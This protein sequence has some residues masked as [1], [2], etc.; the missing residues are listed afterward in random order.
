VVLGT[1]L[2]AAPAAATTTP[3]Q[4]TSPTLAGSGDLR[5][6]T[7]VTGDQ[8]MVQ[9]GR[10]RS[11][12]PGEGRE[13]MTFSART[14]GGHDI[15]VPADAMRLVSQGRLDRRLFDVTTLLEFG[16]DDERRDTLPLI[17]THPENRPAPRLATATVSREL[18]SIEAVAITATKGRQT[19]EALTDGTTTRRTAG[20]VT[21][22]WLDGKRKSTLEHSVPQI[23]APAAWEAGLTGEGTTVAVL[24]TGVDQTHPDLADRETAERNFTDAPDNVDRVGHGTHV[25]SIVA[26]T[27]AKSDGRFRGV[28]SGTRILDG[29][30]LDDNGWGLES[31]IVAG[32]EWA[33]EQGADV[34]NMSLGGG[35]TEGIDPLEEAVDTLSAEHGT[36][37]VIAAGNSGPDAGSV[38][39]PGSA[40]AA[41]TVGAVDRDDQLADFSSR[42]P[43]IGDGGIK[44]DITAPGV[45]IVAALHSEGT[46]GEPVVDG[47]TPLS[48]T[49]MATPHVSG[50]AALLA[51]RHPDWT[52]ARLKAAL[53]AS[54]RPNPAL[55]P[56]EQGSG[57]VDVPAALA[58]TVVTEPTSVGLGTAAWP[59]DDDQPVSQELT[60]QNLSD[61][62]L[63]L[64]LSIEARGPDGTP[65]DL[66]SLSA[67]ELTVPAGGTASVTVTGDT[68]LG[69]ADG[70]YSGAVVATGN[71]STT[72]TPVAITREVESYD[73]TVNVLGRDGEPTADYVATLGGLDNLEYRYP[74]DE[75]GSLR[76][77]VPK[78]RYLLDAVVSDGQAEHLH[79]ILHPGLL[80]DRDLTVTADARTTRPIQVTPPADADLAL[81]DIGYTIETET[82]SNNLAILTHD[83]STVSTA[84]IADELPGSTLTGKVNT[85]WFAE[86][87]SF[88]GLSWF[89]EGELPTGFER[90]VRQRDLATL[91]AEWGPGPEGMPGGRSVVPWPAEG[92]AFVASVITDLPVPGMRTEYVTTEGGIRWFTDLWLGDSW[93]PV[94]GLTSPFTAYRAGRTYPVRFNHAVFGPALPPEDYPWA[95]RLGDELGVNI[96]LFSDSSGNAGF[97]A[98]ESARTQLYRGEELVG[99]T[100]DAGNGYFTAL[101]AEPGRYR[102]VTTATRR[103]TFDLTTSVSAEWTFSSSHV[104]EEEPVAVDLNVVR[105]SPVLDTANSAPA[106]Q[107]FL[108]PLQLQDQ[109]GAT[110]R[111]KS[112]EVE[113]SYDRG[114]NWQPVRVSANQTAVLHH[115][116]NAETVSLRADATDREGNTVRQTIIDAYK[117][118]K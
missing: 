19:W 59:H 64:T 94:V 18:P 81:G 88:Y 40:D 57:R 89:P 109:S 28:A 29:K 43:R 38:G 34:V 71:G 31:S 90:V 24:D 95:Y 117:L 23:G 67:S 78:G 14:H 51:Q 12:E 2:V 5:T 114:A 96:P 25:A 49:S 4:A 22:I 56:F 3:P 26:G 74:Y 101:P 113:V 55:T 99:E 35:D 69:Q 75:D 63:A 8:V 118:R 15:V 33:A 39:S 47:Y 77:R 32:M 115:P 13:G 61:T 66:F 44:P 100:A 11:V 10:V 86:D 54:A 58:Q 30:I 112:M 98:V 104:D 62:E 20:G 82:T 72:R 41:L 53:T 111:P 76:I 116:A 87:G 79:L 36:L 27:G 73:L 105:F 68:R 9:D 7:L 93:A 6:V 42:G 84:Q 80:V 17:V 108:V 46:I 106:G 50:T 83:L 103:K 102:L 85:Q 110:S 65:A 37:F 97:S 60:Y 92:G 52:G 107:R 48:G 21:K 91:R 16:Y 45:E 70:V 1:V